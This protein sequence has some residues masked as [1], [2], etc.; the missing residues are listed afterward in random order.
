MAGIIFYTDHNRNDEI[1]ICK[2]RDKPV[3]GEQNQNEKMGKFIS[4]LRKEKGLTQKELA[5]QLGVTDKAVSKWERAVSSPDIG[6][7]IP[8][9]KILG[10]S[11]GELLSGER[12]EESAENMEK[13]PEDMV[14]EALNYSHRTSFR[15]LRKMQGLIFAGMSGIFFI[16]CMVCLICDYAISRKLSWSWIVLVSLFAAWI[17]LFPLFRAKE[18]RIRKSLAVLSVEVFPY[19]AVLSFLLQVPLLRTMG[20]CIGVLAVLGLWGL[21]MII[22]HEWSRRRY[23][24]IGMICSLMV[25]EEYGINLIIDGF[26]GIVATDKSFVFFECVVMLLLAAASFGVSCY[27]THVKE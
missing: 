13:D 15:K 19:L 23:F 10:V 27:R 9:A 17:L 25:A 2:E 14:E 3:D 4:G 24:A 12:A 20:M 22:V 7:L 1:S 21:Y 16:A 26:L 5:E 18:H 6:L 11:A 8:L